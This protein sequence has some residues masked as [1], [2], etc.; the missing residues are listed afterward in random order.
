MS[1]TVDQ[2]FVQQYGRSVLSLAQQ[3]GS[4]LRGCV[5]VESGVVGKSVFI[6]RIGTTAAVKRTSRHSDSPL[7]NIP[8]SRRRLDLA[9]Y[10]QGELV[11]RP[12]MV[13]TLNDPTNP[14][15]RA[16]GYA[17]G[18]AM[19]NECIVAMDGTAFEGAGGAGDAVTS[20]AFPAAQSIAVDFRDDAAPLSVNLTMGKLRQAKQFLD[21]A[22]VDPAD[23]RYIAVTAS[24]IHSLLFSTQ[25][26]S[27]DFQPVQALY[28]GKI[29]T[30]LDFNFVRTQL[31]P[32]SSGVIRKVFCWAK[33]GIRLGIGE[34]MVHEVAPRPDKSYSMYPYTRMSIGATRAED[35]RVVRILC[36]E[37]AVLIPAPG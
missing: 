19:D 14:Y 8:H 10:E 6:D 28:D 31:L 26:T 23:V 9:D 5:Q 36:D 33:S 4:R 34:D 17:M 12:D 3:E 25:V 21:T 35:V 24:Q 11:D 27:K 18:R 7:A 13:R 2:W 16:I 30:L 20:V 1:F 32:F 22:D 37:A 29:T 15:T